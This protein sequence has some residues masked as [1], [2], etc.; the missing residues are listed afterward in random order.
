MFGL[1][2]EVRRRPSAL[3]CARPGTRQ[4][5]ELGVHRQAT[6]N[7]QPDVDTAG[8]GCTQNPSFSVTLFHPRYGWV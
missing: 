4:G 2:P 3:A 7:A 1:C 8:A 6:L 5:D